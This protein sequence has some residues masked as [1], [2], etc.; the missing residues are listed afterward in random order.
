MVNPTPVQTYYVP[1]REDDTVLEGSAQ[2]HVE[3]G[4]GGSLQDVDTFS[5]V[6]FG[7]AAE[8][9]II[10]YDNAEDGYELNAAD[11]QQ[12]T[13]F[14][15]GD[16]DA[17]NNGVYI[18]ALDKNNDGTVDDSED[19]FF[20]G[21]A[22][23]VTDFVELDRGPNDIFFDGS[24]KISATFPIAVSRLTAPL[25]N[26]NDANPNNDSIRNI[27]T[28][29]VEVQDT[30]KY[31]DAYV[32][33]VGGDGSGN[34]DAPTGAFDLAFAHI[35]AAQ[36]GTPVYLNGTLVAT[37][38]EG[39]TFVSPVVEGD[40]ITTFDAGAG[41]T[42]GP[43]VQTTLITRDNGGEDNEQRWYS[44]SPV[45]DWSSDYVT[46]VGVGDNF[47]GGSN[48]GSSVWLYNDGDT[49]IDVEVFTSAGLLET[50]TVPAGGSV[51]SSEIPD[52]SGAR[53]AS[54]GD[55]PF[56]AVLQ[57]DS[58]G[59]GARNDWGHPLI[60]I[61]QLTSQGLVTFGF[62]N[63][64]Q[65][66]DGNTNESRSLTFV[67]PL[68]DAVINVDFDGDG[69]VDLVLTA[70]ALESLSI[71]DPADV[72]MTGALIFAHAP[73]DPDT[74][75]DI[76]IAHG[77]DPAQN[78]PESGSID[79]GVVTIPLP[80]V[81]SS[82]SNELTIDADNNGVFSPG[83]TVTFTINTLNFGRIDIG[84]GGY[85]VTDDFTSF[86]AIGDYVANSTTFNLND[87]RGEVAL[88][89]S[90]SGTIFPLD[91]GFDTSG[92][93]NGDPDSPILNTGETHTLSFQ[94]VLKDFADLPPGTVS[95]EN[96][97]DLATNTDGFLN[98][99]SSSGPLVFES[100]IAVEKTTNGEDADTGTG[101]GIAVGETVTWRY[102]VTNTGETFLNNVAVSD[103]NGTPGDTSDD[104]TPTFISG[105]T[106]NDGL[107]GPDET[108]VF[109]ATGT[110]EAGQYR[111]IGTVSGDA[112]YSD[113]SAVPDSAGGGTVTNTDPSAYLGQNLPGIAIDKTVDEVDAAGNGI[114][115]AAGEI[116]S[117]RIEVTNTGNVA[118]T[119]VVVTDDNATPGTPGDDVVLTLDSGDTDN[120]GE[121]DTDETW[122]YTFDRA[123][124]QGEIDA[125]ADIVNTAAVDTA[126]TDPTDDDATV[127]VAQTADLEIV[128]S[129]SAIDTA[130]NGVLD[131]AGEIV[132]YTIEVSNAGNT[133]LTDVVVT[134][135]NATPGDTSDDLTL[136]LDSGDTD[137]DGELDTDETWVYSYDRAVT[138]DELDAGAD[139]INTATADS[140]ETDPESD[141]ATVS[142]AQNAAIAIEKT[143]SAVDTAG[144]GV[145]DAAGEIVTYTIEV[146]NGG[147]TSLTDVVVTDDNATPGDTSDDLT[148]TLDSGDTDNDGELDVDETWV[149]SYDRA[150]TQDEIDAGADL[151]NTATGDSDETGPESDDATVSVDQNAA[152][153][154]VK[155]ASAVDTAGNGVLDAAGEIV[156]YTIEVTNEGNTSL[157]DVEVRDDN[158]TPADF[159]DDL[160]LTLDSG[161]TDNDG[162][163]DV[164]ETWVYSY[165]RAVTQDEIDAGNDL[166]N[167][168]TADSA[169]TAPESDE[170]TVSVT[171]NASL[172][173]AKAATAIDTA[174]NGTL[175]AA[176]EIVTYTVEVTNTGNTSLTD[177]VVTDDNATPGDTS[178]DLTLTLDS[179]DT[180]ND[181]ELDTDETWVYTYD[182]AITQDE[183]DAGGDLVNTATADSDE[184]DP[185]SA[186]ETVGVTQNASLAI[187]KAA[188]AIDTAGNGTLD[189]AGE[190]VTY[191]VEVTNTGNTSLTD[192]VVT[193]DNATP[194]DTS[195]DL[196]LTLDSGDTDNDGELD[197]DET[198]VYTYDRAITQAEIDAGGDLVNT[199]TADSD[200]TDPESADETVGVTQTPGVAIEKTA[201]AVDTAGNGVLDAAGEI[202][203]YAVEV[204]NTGNTSLTDVVVTDDNATA[205]PSDDLTLTLTSGDTDNDGELDTDETWRYEYDRAVTQGEIDAGADVVNTATV[206]T[207]ETDPEDDDA[208]VPITQTP[209]VAI[210]KTAVR[211]GDNDDG[212][213]DRAGETALFRITVNNTGNT[214]LTDVVVTDDNATADTSDDVV[215]TLESGDTDNDGELDVGETWTYEFERAVTVQDILQGDDLTNTAT[216]DTAETG[217]ESDDATVAV[218]EYERCA[219]IRD[220]FVYPDRGDA[221]I[222]SREQNI[223]GTNG[224]DV[225]FGGRAGQTISVN[226]GQNTVVAGGGGDLINGGN[227]S[228]LVFAGRGADI[229][230]ANGGDDLIHTGR[231]KDKVYGG[232]GDDKIL[233][234]RHDDLVEAGSGDDT[235]NLGRGND[236]VQGEGGDDCIAG[237]KDRGRIEDTGNG[238]RAI[239]GDELFGNGGADTFEYQRG[240]G[241][242][243]LFDFKAEDGDA[244]VLFG[245]RRD[246]AEAITLDTPY[247]PAAALAFD[248]DG[249]GDFDGAVIFQQIR[250]PNQ[251]DTL[252]NDNDITFIV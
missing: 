175:D 210:D 126:E 75:V 243:F 183:I 115:D 219:D 138:Q 180:D 128:K 184:T 164:D 66:T 221:T 132:T 195:D 79:A 162:E 93:G 203:T 92:R 85:I 161:D 40:R 94:V 218:G 96:T 166:T 113:G 114:L 28:G 13:T 250:D 38:D 238:L 147:N 177:V 73:G 68:E 251:I 5:L 109:E 202:V 176:G 87:G 8:N 42:T 148:L 1:V 78:A 144:N 182:R 14:V 136:T 74:P 41:E 16:G 55:E 187:A 35:M 11:P 111:N 106:N 127:S 192:V 235:I 246:E 134:D 48:G 7:V 137:N 230:N 215:L 59:S 141:D 25:E 32:I 229:V 112:A 130:G 57:V 90:G 6:S 72:N 63:T 70:N 100:G 99:F 170:E 95:F 146:T 191:T 133:S 119:D 207:A 204:T 2:G 156:T 194:G 110:A 186:D 241:V 201:T 18:E 19:V 225:V 30:T 15:W 9:T 211:V 216:V 36:N 43:G 39:E 139:L 158:A 145:L 49:A 52:G 214:T 217:P 172:A 151:V 12:A 206:D 81:F 97:G 61:E 152:I 69:S 21:E 223:N 82:K 3:I 140:D 84:E 234:G 117:F 171:Q 242:D 104:F 103:D 50:L 34:T 159:S 245:I 65:L 135:D 179:G 232:G 189:A 224:D 26:S 155:T 37:L 227:D 64:A 76:A 142:V 123:V 89:D 83:D 56:Y 80:E 60:P 212:T 168:A 169:E 239:L 149:Y 222:R 157:T 252:I 118:L 129:A 107:L 181:G 45:E 116:A 124:T 62:G 233:T 121:L 198:W 102:E 247:G 54:T 120:D 44:L 244:L 67:T 24:D 150:V 46:P 240:D 199:A 22:F 131:A 200:E 88:A 23:N 193:D 4:K 71:T 29:S 47:N 17:T 178:D 31:G 237:G 231:G 185:E 248:T 220:H 165:D 27:A 51:E 98:G 153:G 228:D 213:L 58:R 174:G 190:I 20:G 188:T 77:Q 205:D 208:T 173:I 236:T 53:F 10:T 249:D 196:T 163:L 101:P 91:E 143:A 154:I 122:V 197:T 167:T 226:E 33:P 105:D 86:A 108:W 160:T 209:G 125:G